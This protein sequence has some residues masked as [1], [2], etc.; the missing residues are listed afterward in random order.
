M[1]TYYIV[2]KKAVGREA[3]TWTAYC[4]WFASH[5]IFGID[6]MVLGTTSLDDADDC[7]KKLRQTLS[8]IAPR[9]VRVVKI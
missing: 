3:H 2:E 8:A 4:G 1:K 5:G 6:N 9:V 7:E